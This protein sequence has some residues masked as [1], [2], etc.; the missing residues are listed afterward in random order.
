LLQP[1]R[2]TGVGRHRFRQPFGEN[3]LTAIVRVT[4]KAA[5]PQSNLHRDSTPGQIRQASCGFLSKSITIPE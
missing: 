2:A 1:E 4:E 3:P 5:G